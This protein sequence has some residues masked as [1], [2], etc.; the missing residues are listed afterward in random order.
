[1]I[2]L[3]H[4]TYHPTCFGYFNPAEHLIAENYIQKRSVHS[5]VLTRGDLRSRGQISRTEE[6]PGR[7]SPPDADQALVLEGRHDEVSTRLELLSRAL[8]MAS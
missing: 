4:Q 1:M 5:G 8:I 3:A 6:D 2:P 7:L